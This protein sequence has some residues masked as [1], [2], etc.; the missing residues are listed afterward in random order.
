M[1]ARLK[2]TICF[3]LLVP[4]VESFAARLE[5][6]S[7]GGAALIRSSVFNNQ[8]L[9]F[10]LNQGQAGSQV[11]FLAR[12][13][14]YDFLITSTE[15]H[16]ILQRR[17]DEPG[18]TSPVELHGP[19]G[20]Q[21]LSQRSIRIQFLGANPNAA[22]HGEAQM[23][24]KINYLLG[25][26]SDQWHVGIPTYARVEVEELY[27]N[28]NLVYHG[29]QNQL[30]YD[31]CISPGANPETITIHFDGA[32]NLSINPSGELV[33]KLGSEEVHQPCP[34]LFQVV[35]GVTKYVRGHYQLKG[36]GNVIFKVEDYDPRLPL[37]IDP[38]LTYSSYFGG[39]GGDAAVSVK[40]D[41][42]NDVYVAGLT[43][44][45][46]SLT[47]IS[48]V[49]FAT[50]FQGGRF[51]GDG[52][53]AK[54]DST[55][56]NLLF[57]TYFGGTLDDGI[58]D[59][60]LDPSGN[61]YVTG[62]TDSTN[63]PVVLPNSGVGG[64]PSASGISGS[65]DTNA[66]HF[67]PVDAFVAE[68]DSSGMNLLYSL[69]LGGDAV[70]VGSGIAVDAVGNAY[71]TGYTY[72][73][74]FPT[75]NSYQ[76]TLAGT[77][78][79]VNAFIAR[80]AAGATN[81]DYASYLGGTNFDQAEGIAVDSAGFA[82]VTGFTSSTNFPTTADALR[83]LL[84]GQ[85]NG[86]R[87]YD[88]FI[89]RFDTTGSGAASLVYSSY[90]GGTNADAGNRI[91]VDPMANVYVT[92]Y[93]YSQDFPNTVTNLLATGIGTNAGGRLN[94]DAFL[95]KFN[96]AGS[97]PSLLFSTVF[98]G[99][100]NDM[101]WDV[102]LDPAGNSVYVAGIT[103]STGFPIFDAFGVLRA[104]NSGGND[105]FVSVFTNDASAVLYSAYLGGSGNDF[106]FGIA[107][108]SD[109]SAYV[110]GRTLST[111]F[112]T[113]NPLQGSRQSSN[114][115]FVAK[116]VLTNRL[117]TVMIQTTPADLV[118]AVDGT[119]YL[120]PVTFTNWFP[121]TPRTLTV[122]PVQET[123]NSQYVWASWSD[124]G[125]LSHTIAPVIDSTFSATFVAQPTTNHVAVVV[126]GGGSIT[127]NYN[128]RALTIGKSYTVTAK[129]SN[130]YLFAGWTGDYPSNKTTLTF[131]MQNGLILL[132]NFIPNP[133][134]AIQGSY[135]GLFS[136]TN[137]VAFQSSGYFSETLASR[138]SFSAKLQLA[139]KAYSFSGLF[140]NNGFFSNSIPRK[141]QT[142]LSVV[143]QHD[144]NGN[145][146][147]GQISD[148]VWIAD[149]VANRRYY[150]LANPAPQAFYRYT[151]L[152]PGVEDSLSL[153]GGDGSG[154][155]SV[156]VAGN[157]RF[158]GILGDGT[159]VSPVTFLS[160]N[161]DWP[162]FASLYSGQGSILGWLRF[163]SETNTD[164]SG[165]LNW[166][167]LPQAGTKFYP[168][169]FVLQS[170][171]QGSIYSPIYFQ[172]TNGSPVLNFT[173]GQVVLTGGNL[174][175]SITNEIVLSGNNRVTNQSN[176][177][178]S[179]SITTSSGLFRGSVIDPATGRSIAFNGA[180]L[181]KQNVGK[182][183]FLGTNQ[184]G[185]VLFAPR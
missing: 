65:P 56:T 61:V 39:K 82:Y 180:V 67:F 183:V 81:L 16:V 62:F 94:S 57:L 164:I 182:G 25:N 110:V 63:F 59:M 125:F 50:D 40:V 115:A 99:T 144:F 169:G 17:F 27:P 153:P 44:S 106:G 20:G 141:G 166:F 175:Q 120:A 157:V 4:A 174:M 49:G 80:I 70:D 135:A 136:D 108:D 77:N 168:N 18:A 152:V 143:L 38:L 45:Q 13:A 19:G 161:G 102:A 28:I 170:Q 96:F 159:K 95:T 92:G 177:R 185:R 32:D 36:C 178:L 133:F 140:S 147:T 93:T 151:M 60:A 12:G 111:N 83:P 51:S 132:A 2:S 84:N 126:N 29:D 172:T 118:V 123:N 24:G 34:R 30:E 76:N 5:S 98:G 37:T 128:G 64:L 75:F 33:I 100:N 68:L 150:S 42:S 47:N 79:T 74:N 119:N 6:P 129:P 146:L 160:G 130:G 3:L 167:K 131:V 22:V 162:F 154:A 142:P 184:T 15:A 103:A 139:G 173:N 52:F 54:F 113:V 165:Q 112:P 9:H 122:I 104:T 156:D 163:F 46:I 148:G 31:F 87:A 109:G 124:R 78:K 7:P 89:S 71:V 1:L 66:P 116:I 158:S 14:N 72:S 105:A 88:A 138:G 149:L 176:N 8:P 11:R 85:T 69:Y 97:P 181:Q 91:T 26:R 134:I 90:L 53:I 171:V 58:Y 41:A 114:T 155:V 55:L 10:E 43:L 127:P 121:G 145:A 179:V 48:P 101:G 35:N 73:T 86:N 117:L 137:G 23:I 107:A 21:V